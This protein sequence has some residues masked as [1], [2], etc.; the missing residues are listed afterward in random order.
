M[1]GFTS[2]IN[3]KEKPVPLRKK[4]KGIRVQIQDQTQDLA[5][6]T[7]V[8]L[9]LTLS[10]V[11]KHA[12]S[13]EKKKY[14]EVQ[15][16]CDDGQKLKIHVPIALMKDVVQP[17]FEEEVIIQGHKEGKKIILDEISNKQ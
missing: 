1:V 7:I 15:L 5:L 14:G 9:D 16:L 8:S 4:R 2:I 6:Q 13:L 10:G 11:L 12:D 17:Y 3:G